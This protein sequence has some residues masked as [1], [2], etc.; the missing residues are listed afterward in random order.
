MEQRS[1]PGPTATTPPEQALQESER[2]YRSLFEAMTEVFSECEL[3]DDEAGRPFDVRFLAVNPAFELLT[4]RQAAEVIGRTSQELFGPAEPTWLERYARV[5]ATGEPVHFTASYGPLG[6]WFQVSAYRTG[7][8]RL[9]MVSFDISERKRDE[10]AL[11]ASEERHRLLA[12]TLLLGVVHQA[13]DGTIIAMNPAAVRILGKSQGEFL[14]SSSVQE[15]RDCIRADGS[16]FPGMEHPAMVA[17]R[18]GQPVREVPMGVF[19]PR[20]R[21]YR[22]ITIS[23]VPL[24]RAGDDRPYEVYTVFADITEHKQAEEALARMKEI[25]TEGERIAH[26]GSFEY[27]AD[28]KTTVWSDEE[29]RIY[30]L[31]PAGT[32]PAYEVMLERCIHPDDAPL[33]HETFSAAMQRGG[34]Y[35][36]EH[37]IVRP[38]GEVRWVHDRARPHFDSAGKLVRYLGATVDVTERKLAEEAL[39]RSEER[40]K[41]ATA[42]TPDHLLVQDRELRYELVV[43]P[44]L[45]FAEADMLGKTDHDFLQPE[46]AERLTRIKRRVLETGEQVRLEAPVINR[47]GAQEIFEGAYVPRFDHAGRVDG[48]IGYF[49][50]V[51][52]RRRTEESLRRSEARLALLSETATRLLAAADPQVVVEDLCR[53][54]MRH[55]DCQAFFNFLVDEDAGRL[56]LN[57]WAGIPADEARRIE[58]LDFGVAVCGCAAR[59]GARIIAEDILHSTDARANLVRSYGIQAHC[60]HPLLAEGRVIGT[61]SFGTKSR[62][63]FTGEEVE[64]MRTVADQVAAAMERL[65]AKEALSRAN[66]RLVEADRAKDE[67]L[68]VLSHELRNPLAPIRNSVLVLQSAP[69]GGEQATRAQQIIARQSEHLARLVDDLLDLNR[70]SRGKVELHRERVD[71]AQLVFRTAED[72]RANF[73]DR[74]I[75]FEVEIARSPLWLD[76]DPTRIAQVVGN[77]LGNAAKFTP[78]GGRVSVRVGV[79]ESQA[80]VRVT[81]T[82]EG[83]APELLERVFDP[84]TQAAQT[85]A[86][87]PGGLGLGLALVKGFV[88]MHDGTVVARSGG[89][90]RG[91]EFVV[92]LALLERVVLDTARVAEAAAARA[93]RVAVIEDNRDAAE[94]LRDVLGL[95]GHEARLAF[96]GASGLALVREMRPDLVLC[97]IG[98][99]DMD[100]HAVV[101]ALRAEGA[102]AARLVALSGYAQPEDVAKARAAGFDDHL[103]KPPSLEKLRA[104]LASVA[105]DPRGG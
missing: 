5:V 49:R 34:V 25:L 84:F 28:P 77:L 31:D 58:W 102:L 23:A 27:V 4:G 11:R 40:F 60:C 52:D 66:A 103:A 61:L 2:R 75:A 80:E 79:E 74:G 65:L 3:V 82:G 18:T 57:A 95:L 97:D 99:P 47:D 35:E 90:G 54:V 44:Q 100:G 48:L 24:S 93:L 91:S 38:D 64:L 41:V 76:A 70:I 29:Y 89:V 78:R 13:R 43:N 15:E 87:I 21:R 36:L 69:P 39:R 19:N 1:G 81:D 22:W 68:A 17:L 9:A 94:S 7:P 101:G 72:H 33:L 50:N 56:H 85:L 20:E 59:D 37:R 46:D 26:V 12:D 14:G 6:R 92:R 62:A 67:F 86:R 55:L 16:P 71:L 73:H 10:E 51:T 8:G 96:D 63:S 98:L 53:N 105:P 30:G 88:E 32:S 83:I 42:S 45:G 104:L